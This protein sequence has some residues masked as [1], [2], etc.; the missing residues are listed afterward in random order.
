MLNPAAFPQALHMTLAAYA[1]TGFVV[2]GIHAFMLLRDPQN[3]F[4]KVALAIALAV[5]GVSSIL[6]PLSGDLL[7]KRVAKTQPVKL[8]AFEGQF[9]TQ[10][11]APFRIVGAQEII[12]GDVMPA[13][14]IEARDNV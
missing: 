10:T 1:A 2:A 3:R 11:G 14:L 4:H 9:E 6:Q 12:D 5:G 13:G 7:A 8:A